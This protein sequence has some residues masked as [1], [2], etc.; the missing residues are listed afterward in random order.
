MRFP[1]YSA[2]VEEAKKLAYILVLAGTLLPRQAIACLPCQT[3]EALACWNNDSERLSDR[4][5]SING[6]REVFLR[7]FVTYDAKR[8]V[9][10]TACEV[11]RSGGQHRG[12][13]I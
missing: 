4:W 13:P 5:R 11:V 1:S 7:N 9:L 10:V 8:Q 12:Y 3:K 6:V 2:R